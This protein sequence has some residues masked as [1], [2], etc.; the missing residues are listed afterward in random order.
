MKNH[1]LGEPDNISS[2]PRVRL[3]GKEHVFLDFL[4]ERYAHTSPEIHIQIGAYARPVTAVKL[5]LYLP[6]VS[7]FP[8]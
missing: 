4:L 8:I 5:E 7:P 6:L 3:I 1:Y 2:K